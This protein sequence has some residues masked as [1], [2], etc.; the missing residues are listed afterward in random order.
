MSSSERAGPPACFRQPTNAAK[1]PDRSARLISTR[2]GATGWTTILSLRARFV[3][4][5]SGNH[6]ILENWKTSRL[7]R[8]FCKSFGRFWRPSAKGAEGREVRNEVSWNAKILT[9]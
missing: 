7:S 9:R 2:P 3:P 5:P 6:L 1:P 4:L 8:G